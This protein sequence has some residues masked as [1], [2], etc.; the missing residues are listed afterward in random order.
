MPVVAV[1]FGKAF[2][3]T[4]EVAVL[5]QVFKSVP[6]I[7][8]TVVVAGLA[9]TLAPVVALNPVAGDHTYV[10]APPALSVV[11]PPVQIAGELTVTTG[12]G[13]TIIVIVAVAVQPK[14]FPVTV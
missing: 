14:E 1:T 6:V 10:F 2:T 4:V 11:E 3:V 9:V 13:F 5:V 8:Y 12:A 7:V